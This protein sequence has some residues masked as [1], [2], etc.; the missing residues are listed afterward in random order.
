M[1]FHFV[2]G[3]LYSTEVAVFQTLGFREM[4][5]ITYC[6][7]KCSVHFWFKVEIMEV[8]QHLATQ[9]NSTQFS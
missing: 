9:N 5:A 4:E 6:N 1:T 8:L 7:S 2:G 3:L